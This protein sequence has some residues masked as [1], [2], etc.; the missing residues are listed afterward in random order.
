MQFQTLGRYS[1]RGELG[2]GSMGIVYSGHDPVIDR[3]IALKTVVF[4][5]A[6]TPEERRVFLERFFMEARTAGRLA[7]PNIVVIHD[8]AT[9]EATGSPS[10]PWSSSK[11]NPSSRLLQR[12]GAMDWGDAVDIAASLADALDQAHRLGVVHRD[13][14]PANIVLTE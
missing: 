7:H 3:P 4:P 9:D 1:V 14:K 11:A 5:D 10:S 8:A 6:L 12:E 2:R 13:I